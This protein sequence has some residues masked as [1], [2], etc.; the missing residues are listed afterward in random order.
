MKPDYAHRETDKLIAELEKELEKAYAEAYESLKERTEDYF[1][2]FT[3]KDEKWQVWVANG[4]K[5]EEQYKA[6]RESQMMMGKRWEAMRDSIASDLANCDKIAMDFL[7]GQM[8]EIFALNHNWATYQIEKGL[9]MSTNYTLYNADAVKSLLKEDPKLLPPRKVPF[10][11]NVAWNKKRVQATML[12]GILQGQSIP[13]MAKNLAGVSDGNLNAAI[14]NARTMATA[15]Q[16]AGRQEAYI[17]AKEK[18]ARIRKTWL[19]T[20]DMRTRHEH[21]I[22]DGQTVEVDEPFVVEGEEIMY[23]GDPT[24][25]AHLVYNCRCRTITKVEG[26]ERDVQGFDLRSDPDVDGMSYEEWKEDRTEKPQPITHQKDVGEA[27]RGY[28]YDKYRRG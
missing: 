15:A 2:R 28:F 5:T 22:L 13:A 18:G 14:R 6:W 11:E 8:P 9:G 10:P 4:T 20:L 3:A 7:N 1:R 21:R 19:A 23:P 26:F 24:A 12:Q 27:M 17:R 25:P 16:N